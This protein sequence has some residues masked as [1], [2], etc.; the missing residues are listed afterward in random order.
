MER[1]YILLIDTY[2]EGVVCWKGEGTVEQ[3]KKDITELVKKGIEP[4]DLE[5]IPV[6]GERRN[7]TWLAVLGVGLIIG[8]GCENLC[9]R[10][11]KRRREH[12]ST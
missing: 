3:V 6:V 12:P 1:K 5:A 2:Q 7:Y 11:R 8:M 9:K 4:V 10:I